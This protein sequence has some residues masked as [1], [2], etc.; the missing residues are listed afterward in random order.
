MG[1]NAGDGIL[2]K[3]YMVGW[4]SEIGPHRSK[5]RGRDRKEILYFGVAL[6]NRATEL[7][8]IGT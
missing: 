2:W 5:N 7:F 4:P 1:D 3:F 6:G 8:L